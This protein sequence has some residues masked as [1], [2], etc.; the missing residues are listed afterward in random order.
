MALSAPTA[1]KLLT[2]HDW[3]ALNGWSYQKAYRLLRQLPAAVKVTVGN[4]VYANE[5]AL[6][7]WLAAGGDQAAS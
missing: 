2:A 7:N 4:R 5:Q 6:S 3:A 1:P